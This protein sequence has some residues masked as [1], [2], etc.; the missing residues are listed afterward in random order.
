[1][2][3][4]WRILCREVTCLNYIVK[5]FLW[6][7]CWENTADGQEWNQRDSRKATAIPLKW[8]RM[9]ACSRIVA[10]K[11]VGSDGFLGIVWTF[12]FANRCNVEY[13][14]NKKS[15]IMPIFWHEQLESWSCHLQQWRWLQEKQ[16][17]AFLLIENYT[18]KN[19]FEC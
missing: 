4:Y 19:Q 9:A 13:K 5:G 11:E 10:T 2:G 15:E 6:T 12:I 18:L 16:V 1:M 14:R 8:E 7:L 17:D 3:S